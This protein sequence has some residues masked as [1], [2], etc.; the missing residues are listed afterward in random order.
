MSVHLY[1][2]LAAALIALSAVV[3][4]PPLVFQYTQTASFAALFLANVLAVTFNVASTDPL[5]Q[6]LM[7]LVAVAMFAK[8]VTYFIEERGVRR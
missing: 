7:S 3:R 4:V 1:A 8:T 5:V 6:A 2:I